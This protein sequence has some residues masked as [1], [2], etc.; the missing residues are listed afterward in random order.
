MSTTAE[1][2][3][4]LQAEVA[5]SKTLIETQEQK[6][7][8]LVAELRTQQAAEH[9]ASYH[10]RQSCPAGG[11]SDPPYV[12][13]SAEARLES[14]VTFHRQHLGAG[15]PARFSVNTRITGVTYIPHVIVDV[16]KLMEQLGFTIEEVTSSMR[17]AG[18]LER[19]VPR[20]GITESETEDE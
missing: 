6:I 16:G 18:C 17:L 20:Y 2:L 11:A 13:C 15:H 4:E 9:E 14:R 10:E 1:I 3:R 19:P 5:S 8:E 12:L 7:G